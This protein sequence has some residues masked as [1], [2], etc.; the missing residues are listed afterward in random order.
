MGKIR[1]D[2]EEAE[3]LDSYEAGEWRT[4]EG[5]EVERERYQEVARATFSFDVCSLHW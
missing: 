4:I 3:L 2:R 5:W 1:L